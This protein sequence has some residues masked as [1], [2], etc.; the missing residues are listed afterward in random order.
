MR[1]FH[2]ITTAGH[3][4]PVFEEPEAVVDLYRALQAV[5]DAGVEVVAYAV[6]TS[7]LHLLMGV[8]ADS[9]L[10]GVMQ[11]I[12]GPLAQNMN[13]RTIQRGGIFQHAFWRKPATSDSYL[14]ALPLY[15][16]AN[17][18]PAA[19][20]LR[21]L[22]VGL[23]SS[24]AAYRSG[25]HPAWLRPGAALVQYEQ[26]YATA[27]TEYLLDREANRQAERVLEGPEECVVVAVARASGVRPG[28]LLNAARGGK[29]DRTLLAWAL[30]GELG[31]VAAARVLGVVRHTAAK[32]AAMAEVD[33][34][35]AE[36]RHKLERSLS[37]QK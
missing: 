13:R 23:R 21:R 26:G 15:I 36:A 32:W 34:T 25:E 35:L 30:V 29:R 18:S 4:R 7:H 12:T 28:T 16:H 2:T 3:D 27:M 10:S 33:D 31:S 8:V 6:M 1:Y 20:E 11:R 37:D 19:T 17:L 24:H 9:D 14:Y 22:D 5:T